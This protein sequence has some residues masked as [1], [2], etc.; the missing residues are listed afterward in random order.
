[1]KI[2]IFGRELDISLRS[3]VKNLPPVS[4]NSSWS[5]FL[6]G[7]GVYVSAETALQVAAVIRCVDVVAKTI[8][9]LPL[10]LFKTT[11]GGQK[12]AEEH[13]VYKLLYRLPNSETT[14]F[15]FWLMYI[16]NLMLTKGAFAKIKRDQ[17]G[18][19]TALYNIPTSHCVLDRN[20]RTG[21]RYLD[22]WYDDGDPN[23]ILH[24]RLYEGSFMYTPNTRFNSTVHP[25]DPI[26]IARETLGLSSALDTFASKFFENGAN[27]G[28]IVEVDGKL[29]DTAFE[30]FK[31]SFYEKY[32]G[33]LNAHK[34]MFL[35]N[36]SKYTSIGKIPKD[37]QA[38][39]SRRY[40]VIEICRHFGVPPHK[41]FE[42]ERA[43]FSNIEQMNIEFVQEAIGPTT[44]RLEQTIY[45]DLITEKEQRKLFA[46]FNIKALLRGDI[47][48]QTEFYH[49]MRND[50]V[51]SANHILE[52]EDM[53][54]IPAEDGGND[55]FINGN[56][57]PLS[58]AKYN[59]P[60]A[61]QGGGDNNA[62]DSTGN[63]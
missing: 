42:L 57:I 30:R 7:S 2:S 39:E 26:K 15:E 55:I 44:V 17:N 62:G 56:M 38:L 25:Q 8:A 54:Q 29:T 31:T 13:P 5:D 60:K 58:A 32:S 52:L 9:S 63:N 46:K 40:Q 24:E 27:A 21:E 35:E 18:F 34:V 33:V 49:M 45:K 43:T 50:G 16:F 37:A 51:M 19:I 10:N 3:T 41:V 1:M 12:K 22:V 53:N 36:G 20:K 11:S 47:K 4:S 59:L 14:A 28:G 48:S 23:N 61:M 6:S